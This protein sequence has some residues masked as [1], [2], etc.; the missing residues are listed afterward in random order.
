MESIK[1]EGGEV[2]LAKIVGNGCLT[3]SLWRGY[4]NKELNDEK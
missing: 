3:H 2:I 4:F 1:V